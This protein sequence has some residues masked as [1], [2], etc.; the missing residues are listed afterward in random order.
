MGSHFPYSA[1]SASLSLPGDHLITFPIFYGLRCD[2]F[3]IMRSTLSFFFFLFF[4]LYFI[5]YLD[6]LHCTHPRLARFSYS[7]IPPC[8]CTHAQTKVL[9]CARVHFPID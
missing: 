3:V 7:F 6:T 1:L 5:Q 2:A 4:F 9:A 8:R